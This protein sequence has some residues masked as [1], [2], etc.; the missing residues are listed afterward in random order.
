MQFTE[1]AITQR[2]KIQ[3]GSYARLKH[4]CKLTEQDRANTE[5]EWVYIVLKNQSSVKAYS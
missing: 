5:G 1:K 4:T 3:E 2:C